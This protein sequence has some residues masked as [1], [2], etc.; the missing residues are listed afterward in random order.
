MRNARTD[1]VRKK[2]I[3]KRAISPDCLPP[4]ESGRAIIVSPA[5]IP[6]FGFCPLR[7]YLRES[8]MWRIMMTALE[9]MKHSKTPT[10]T[11]AQGYM[12]LWSFPFERATRLLSANNIRG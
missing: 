11:F 2:S 9:G 12:P 5:S 3:V 6:V 8:V 10:T 4:G 1:L 7:H